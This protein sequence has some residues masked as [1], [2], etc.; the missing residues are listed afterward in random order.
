MYV[1]ATQLLRQRRNST[2]FIKHA[3]KSYF[4]IP[5]GDQDKKWSSHIVCHNCE[6]MLRD[7]TKGKQKELPFGVPMVWREP[8]DQV[9]D[10]YFCTVNTKGVD[11]KNLHN[12]SDSS[13]ST[14]IRPVPHCEELPVPVFCGLFM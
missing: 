14:A 12:I 7:W 5:V 6:E 10:C 13:I 9:T 11:K 8:R 3:Y 2:S 1:G 4:Q